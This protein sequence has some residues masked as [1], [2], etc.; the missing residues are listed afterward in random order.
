ML[1]P[2]ATSCGPRRL[3]VLFLFAFLFLFATGALSQQLTNNEERQRGLELYQ[4][5]NYVAAS[6][7]LKKVVKRNRTDDLA[8]SY[9]G[10][11]LLH[12]PKRTKDAAKAFATALKLRP[13][14]AVAHVG[15]AYSFL[16]QNRSSDAFREAEKALSIEPNTVEAHYIVGMVRLRTGEPAEAGEHAEAAIKMNANF[17]L[18]YLL[19]SQALVSSL[20]YAR[21]SRYA[22]A[23][24]AAGSGTGIGSGSGPGSGPKPDTGLGPGAGAG[25]GPSIGSGPWLTM[26]CALAA[27]A[28]ETYLRL[29]P[30]PEEKRAWSEQLESLRFFGSSH[31][32]DSGNEQVFTGRQVNT[33]AR[34][35]RKPEPQY[36]ESARQAQM[37]GTVALQAVF[38]A[39][40]SVKHILVI[41][42]LPYGLTESSVKAARQIQFTPATFEGRPVSTFIQLEYNFNL[43]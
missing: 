6:D 25:V 11:A 8:W 17:A 27:E 43:Y 13:D 30:D 35:L 38:A 37:T 2:R 14:S 40:G 31:T 5:R 4:Q 18:A 22:Q 21:K 41:E 28:L 23:V 9:L 42:G 29:D 12:Q 7:T 16:I 19:K 36:T 33:R 34:V 1:E 20:S 39:D 24:S 10:L 26:V 15:L 32:A 3:S